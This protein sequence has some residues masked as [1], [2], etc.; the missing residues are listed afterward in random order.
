MAFLSHAA[1]G[2]T[3]AYQCCPALLVPG[4]QFPLNNFIKFTDLSKKYFR[5]F[6]LSLAN[7]ILST[8]NHSP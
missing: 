7:K 2:G 4:S 5:D 1:E 6:L 8:I 3:E